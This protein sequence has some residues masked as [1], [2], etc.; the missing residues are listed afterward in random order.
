MSMP[1]QKPATITPRTDVS[2]SGN[3]T[4]G[5]PVSCQARVQ[6]ARVRIETTEGD[7]EWVDGQTAYV[8][9]LPTVRIGDKFTQG[10]TA[11]EVVGVRAFADED[12]PQYTQ[13]WLDLIPEE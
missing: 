6:A 11:Y 13:I 5:S 10:S 4:Y 2:S 12:L 9:G 3:P 7:V 1:G 8:D